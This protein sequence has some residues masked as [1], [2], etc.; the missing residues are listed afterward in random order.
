MYNVVV[1]A[2]N[3]HFL[4]P[5]LVLNKLPIVR[6]CALEAVTSLGLPG[7]RQF[8]IGTTMN[9]EE[10]RE[11]NRKYR[12][13]H[14]EYFREYQRSEKVKAY[15][16]EYRYNNK[17]KRRRCAKKYYYPEKRRQYYIRNAS[18]LSEQAHQRYIEFSEKRREYAR[19]YGLTHPEKKQI[20][21]HNRRA[22][23][24]GNGG[25]FTVQEWQAMKEF[26]KYTCLC[27]GRKEPEIKLS[28]DHV[29]PLALG[30][31]NSI[32]NI[33]PLCLTCN[34]KKNVKHIDYR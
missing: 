18:R 10:R 27:C 13:A 20:R 14:A 23:K 7:S 2:S 33:Q 30:G 3:G 34:H 22:R 5:Y 6:N 21:D 25:R 1:T 32:E 26:Y 17:E 15:Q 11:Y 31:R 29:L 16:R 24:K 4:L 28:P 8:I 12:E 9:K 19:Q